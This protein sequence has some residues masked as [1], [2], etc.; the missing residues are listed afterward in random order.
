MIEAHYL[1]EAIDIDYNG[2]GLEWVIHC[3]KTKR[4]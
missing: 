3:S 2:C 1:G 4:E